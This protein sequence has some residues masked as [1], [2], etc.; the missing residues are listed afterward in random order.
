MVFDS[1]DTYA[2]ARDGSLLH[3]DVVVAAGTLKVIVEMVAAQ[4]AGGHS[5][6]VEAEF[7]LR[8]SALQPTISPEYQTAVKRRGFAIAL[9]TS[10]RKVAA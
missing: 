3:F 5:P 1:Y 10:R 7:S 6:E 9:R 2:T 4:Y 8:T